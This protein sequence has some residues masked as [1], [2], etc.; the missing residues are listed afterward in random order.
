[1]TVS[2]PQPVPPTLA[3]IIGKLPEAQALRVI[4]RLTDHE[5]I[6]R[7]DGSVTRVWRISGERLAADLSLAG[8]RVGPTTVKGYRRAYI[9]AQGMTE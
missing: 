6:T 5:V 4:D 8:F 7:E 9:Y 2:M 3:A 1:M